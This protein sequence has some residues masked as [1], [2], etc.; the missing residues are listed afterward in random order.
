MDDVPGV[1]LCQDE[2]GGRDGKREAK[3]GA[4]E[5]D[6]GK[7]RDVKD[8]AQIDRRDQNDEGE[9]QIESDHRIDQ[10]RRQWQD[11]HRDDQREEHCKKDIRPASDRSEGY[12]QSSHMSKPFAGAHLRQ[13]KSEIWAVPSEPHHIGLSATRDDDMVSCNFAYAPTV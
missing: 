5:D 3:H 10:H 8:V 11:D 13:G 9:C 4:D 2:P 6:G 7:S 12:G 1:T